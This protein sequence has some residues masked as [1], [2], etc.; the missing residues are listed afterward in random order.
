VSPHL[1]EILSHISHRP[2]VYQYYNK[3]G[4]LLYVGKAKDL[5]K[6]VTSY[7][8]NR[9]QS[10]WTQI[11]IEEVAD[12]KVIEVTSELEA[13][14]LENSLIKSLKPKYNIKLKDDK[15]FP[16]IR[17]SDEPFPTFSITRQVKNDKARYLGPYFS[18][19]Y[20]RSLLKL[21]QELYG[22][23]TASV[24]SYESRSTVPKQIGLGSRNLHN[25]GDYRDQVSSAIKFLAYP[26]PQMEKIVQQAMQ[27]ASLAQRFEQAARLRDR[28]ITLQQLRS[29]QSL[30]SPGGKNQDYLGIVQR[31]NLISVYILFEREGK[32][33][34][35]K[36]FLFDIN[37][38]LSEHEL[39]GHVINYLYINGLPLPHALIVPYE[40]NDKELLSNMLTEQVGR[41]ITLLVP[42]RGDTK[43]RLDM[44]IENASY[45]L[46]LEVMK[47]ERRETGLTDLSN[48]LKLPKLAR[49]VEAF[50][51][52]NLGPT[53]IVGASIVFIDGKPVKKEYRKYKITTPTGQDDFASM[54]ELVY[55]RISNTERPL[56]DLLLI[57]GGKGQLSSACDALKLAK[58]SLPIIAL[59]KK[60]ELI[61]LPDQPEP[62]ALSHAS[63]SLLLLMA[64]RDEV[65]RFVIS[66]HRQRRSKQMGIEHRS[67]T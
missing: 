59:A 39:T 23:K 15:T 47:K 67:Q 38:V 56:P 36:D 51:I 55:R 31:G 9:N 16:F 7:W 4:D 30:F 53:H 40:P 1:Q 60:E 63:N 13:L 18:A 20:I 45:Q 62:L 50:D 52:S 48:L 35:H 54:R 19:T 21:L 14:M 8:Q 6:R 32:I 10:P 42:Q 66:F 5:C 3:A 44:A 17:V 26:Q 49:R 41:K 64:I 46:K 28:L 22:V 12:I 57:D 25:K 58:I 43:H 34:N 33:T 27:Q 29:S 61:Y 11:L 2:G 37:G 24:K 65:H